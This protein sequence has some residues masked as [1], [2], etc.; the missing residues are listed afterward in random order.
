VEPVENKMAAW[1]T[2]E[3]FKA[4]TRY[5]RQS[6]QRVAVVVVVGTTHH[7]EIKEPAEMVVPVVVAVEMEMPVRLVVQL[8]QVH[9]K[10]TTA[11]HLS[12]A[13]MLFIIQAAA[14]EPVRLVKV[15]QAEP[16]QVMAELD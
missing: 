11:A 1:Q 5:F 13:V 4:E 8:R 6:L 12:A 14:A 2:S 3:D 9:R 10:V 16:S 15:N 7:R